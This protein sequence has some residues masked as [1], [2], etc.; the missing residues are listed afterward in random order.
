MHPAVANMSLGDRLWPTLDQAVQNS[1]NSGVTYTVSAG[2]NGTDACTQSPAALPAAI[3]VAAS[4]SADTQASFSNFGRCVD[5]YAPGEAIK[6]A[7]FTS[8]SAYAFYSGTSMAAP[9]AAGAAALYLSSHPGASPAEV[10]QALM[11]NATA[12]ALKGLGS[13][14]PNLLLYV[15]NFGTAASPPP[16][17]LPAD[18]TTAAPA[19]ADTT[20]TTQNGGSSPPIA[21]FTANCPRGRC[22]FDASTSSAGGGIASYTWDFGD[23]SAAVVGGSATATHAY[24][25]RGTFTVTLVVANVAGLAG[26]ST[27]AISL[28]NVK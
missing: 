5:L 3:T 26:R 7:F 11:S 27:L 28:K 8:D 17:T 2:N 10:S 13:G 15:G 23:G 4:T 24:A 20:S 1:I 12:A 18:T 19:P 22:T 21:S 9:H 25:S 14:S 16:A 6:S